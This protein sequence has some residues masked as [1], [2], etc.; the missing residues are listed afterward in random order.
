MQKSTK[1]TT[2]YEVEKLICQTVLVIL[3]SYGNW[4]EP[5]DGHIVTVNLNR[6]SP[7]QMF[8]KKGVLINLANFTRKPLCWSHEGLQIY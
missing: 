8:F 6:S 4:A 2:T 1:S 3:M 7:S 5:S